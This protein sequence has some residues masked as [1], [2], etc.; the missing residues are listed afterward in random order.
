MRSRNVLSAVLGAVIAGL[1]AVIVFLG[2]CAGPGADAQTTDPA[3]ESPAPTGATPTTSHNPPAG[4][5]IVR[6][7]GSGGGHAVRHSGLR[8]STPTKPH[9]KLST[10][11]STKPSTPPHDPPADPGPARLGT[12]SVPTGATYDASP[13]GQAF[14]TVFSTLEAGTGEASS[15]RQSTTVK[16][17]GDTRDAV[18]EVAVSG[19][20]LTDASTRAKV[21]VAANG[22]VVKRGFQ[23]GSDEE[24]VERVSVPLRGAHECT[25][26]L[27]VEIQ[28][29]P[30]VRAD[31]Y[32]N[33]ST[34]DGQFV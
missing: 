19:Y 23:A 24:F 26:T 11:P 8:H 10:K 14:N 2:G 7:G 18:L 25:I 12:A 16:I 34:V 3:P 27:T 6:G 32:I 5:V 17:T 20:A 1:V 33:V 21:D 28:P 9:T 31:G 30:A 22:R 15:K 29:D 13:D 4:R